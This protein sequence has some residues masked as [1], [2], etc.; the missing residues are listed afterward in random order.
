MSKFGVQITKD[1]DISKAKPKDFVVDT[2]QEGSLKI[3]KVLTF[4]C[5]VGQTG[6]TSLTQE[7]GLG[8][9]PVFS[10]FFVESSS[11]GFSTIYPNLAGG[12]LE[13]KVNSTQ[14]IL[15]RSNSTDLPDAAT[16]VGLILAAHVMVFA[17][18]LV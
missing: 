17:E 18:R 9:T 2:T 3:A 14:V 16:Y 13:V 1:V 4:N 5:V 6:I 7:H 12:L 15:A 10:V 8:Y 11:F